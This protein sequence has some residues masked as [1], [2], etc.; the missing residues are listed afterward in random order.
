M[1]WEM[2]TP[3]SGQPGARLVGWTSEGLVATGW[4]WCWPTRVGR[5]VGARLARCA[6]EGRLSLGRGWGLEPPTVGARMRGCGGA[7]L[8]WR[9]RP[10]TRSGR[11]VGARLAWSASE[12]RGSLGRRLSAYTRSCWAVACCRLFEFEICSNGGGLRRLASACVTRT[13]G[14]LGL[15]RGCSYV[16]WTK[17]ESDFVVGTESSMKMKKGSIARERERLVTYAFESRLAFGC[18]WTVAGTPVA[19]VEACCFVGR[20]R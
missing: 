5:L 19:E 14:G 18:T 8:L 15:G 16:G 3:A 12:G 4:G 20:R 1:G 10:L 17:L 13:A 6:S 2:S 9:L 7:S 11:L